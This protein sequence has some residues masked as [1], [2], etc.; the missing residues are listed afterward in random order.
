MHVEHIQVT[1][2]GLA[3]LKDA[4][5]MCKSFADK[6]VNEERASPVR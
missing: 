1:H 3:R 2:Q 5:P 4:L 6:V